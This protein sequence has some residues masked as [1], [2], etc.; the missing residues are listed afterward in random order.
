MISIDKSCFIGAGLHRHVYVHPDNPDYCIKIVVKGDDSESKREQSYYR[1][2]QHR[3][4]SWKM[5]PRFIGNEE[6]DL[7]NGA[8]FELVRDADSNISHTLEYYLNSPE[9]TAANA[10]GIVHALRELEEYLLSNRVITMTLK[11]K[12][13]MYQRISSNSGCL[14]IIDNIGN[15]DLLPLANYCRPIAKMKIARKWQRFIQS[16]RT[17]YADSRPLQECLDRL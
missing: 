1:H 9:L 13:I 12:N 17:E 16:M 6:T 2:L 14:V 4:I 5:L 8:I 15:S 3:D 10:T 11:P 7:G